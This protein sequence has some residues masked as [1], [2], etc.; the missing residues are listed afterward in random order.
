MKQGYGDLFR[1][2]FH[3]ASKRER[4]HE[5]A[6]EE[7]M[8]EELDTSLVSEYVGQVCHREVLICRD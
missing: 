2:G 7:S 4:K 5:Q 1:F 8:L 3:V 6:P